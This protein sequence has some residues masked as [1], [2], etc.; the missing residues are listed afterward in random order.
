MAATAELVGNRFQF[1]IIF[2]RWQNSVCQCSDFNDNIITPQINKNFLTL[3][4]FNK[5]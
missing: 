4:I 3:V 2:D 1:L 5:L